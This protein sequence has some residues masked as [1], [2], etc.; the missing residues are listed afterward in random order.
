MHVVIECTVRDDLF[1]A[2]DGHGDAECEAHDQCAEG[3][4]VV[5]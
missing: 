1:V 5:E 4:K 2:V 3:L